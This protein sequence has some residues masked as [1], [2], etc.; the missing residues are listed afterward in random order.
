M[1]AFMN[2]QDLFPS[3]EDKISTDV[4]TDPAGDDVRPVGGLVGARR[5]AVRDAVRPRPLR[6]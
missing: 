2:E 3:R 4:S 5:A 1:C 6:G